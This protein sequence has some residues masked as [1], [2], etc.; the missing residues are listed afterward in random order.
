M[1]IEYPSRVSIEGI[2]QDSTADTFKTHD[3]ISIAMAAFVGV[4]TVQ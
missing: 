1:L 3:P 4:V 2:D